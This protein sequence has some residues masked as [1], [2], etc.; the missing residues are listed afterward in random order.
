M[1]C[2]A[3]IIPG[4]W[5]TFLSHRIILLR[6]QLLDPT[7]TLKEGEIHIRS[8]APNLKGQDGQLTEQVLGPVLVS[9]IPSVLRSWL[10]ICPGIAPSV[11]TSDRRPE[12]SC[13]FHDCLNQ[14]LK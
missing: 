3:W 6:W 7:G 9:A 2:S 11:Q 10:M 14:F 1:S 4:S 13:Y 5:H 8:S 12:G